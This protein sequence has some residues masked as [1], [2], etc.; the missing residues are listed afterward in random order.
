VS[1]IREGRPGSEARFGRLP[2]RWALVRPLPPIG[3]SSPLEMIGGMFSRSAFPSLW[4]CIILHLNWGVTCH[5]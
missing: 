3:S 5:S 4:R 2:E 1:R